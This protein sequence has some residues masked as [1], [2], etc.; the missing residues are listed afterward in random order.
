MPYHG[1][2]DVRDTAQALVAGIKTQGKNRALIV[3]EWFDN[4]DAVEYLK[5]ARPE[6]KDRLPTLKHSGRTK[7]LVDNARTMKILGVPPVRSW[8]D[9]VDATVDAV[10]AVEKEW[11]TAGVDVDNVLNVY[12]FIG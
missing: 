10:L 8:K 12:R 11:A 6:V 1:Y 9:T 5:E 3:G 2:I 7:A 4:W